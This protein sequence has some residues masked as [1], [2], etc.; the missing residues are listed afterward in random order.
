M[1]TERNRVAPKQSVFDRNS[2]YYGQLVGKTVNG[3][4]VDLSNVESCWGLEFTDGT[5][6]WIMRDEEGNG[7][8][9]LDIQKS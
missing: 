7:P 3:V 4:V 5:T 2:Q 1:P 6:A 9:F 8:G